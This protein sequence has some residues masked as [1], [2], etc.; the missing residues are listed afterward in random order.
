MT[1]I[2]V[3]I[4]SRWNAGYRN[5]PQTCWCHP[6][7][8]VC[9]SAEEGLAQEIFTIPCSLKSKETQQRLQKS[10]S[11]I[12]NICLENG[13][14][15]LSAHQI[16]SSRVSEGRRFRAWSCALMKDQIFQSYW[17]S[18][19]QLVAFTSDDVLL[20]PAF[21]STSQALFLTHPETLAR[22]CL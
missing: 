15:L 17:V 8:G 2:A 10:M 5:L 12:Q 18:D 16:R 3:T 6:R 13:H 7:V 21:G 9:T 14:A 1:A 19:W 11:T 22:Q 4:R 20:D